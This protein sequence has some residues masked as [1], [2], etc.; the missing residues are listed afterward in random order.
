MINH[1]RL[2]I[3][4]QPANGAVSLLLGKQFFV[5]L[6]GYSVI[7]LEFVEEPL[8]FGLWPSGVFTEVSLAGGRLSS[9]TETGLALGSSTRL[10]TSVLIELCFCLGNAALSADDVF[11]HR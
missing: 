2:V 3:E 11:T 7:Q 4:R 6:F 9:R 8:F 10:N 5:P 1:R